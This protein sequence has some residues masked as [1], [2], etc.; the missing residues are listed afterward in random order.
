MAKIP[1]YE[2]RKFNPRI[3]DIN[4]NEETL[5]FDRKFKPK[6]SAI[7]IGILSLDGKVLRSDRSIDYKLFYKE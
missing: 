1:R 6:E 3:G 7:E 5:Y 2:E 4:D